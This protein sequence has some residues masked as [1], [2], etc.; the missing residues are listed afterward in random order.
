[1]AYSLFVTSHILV[2][3]G[4]TGSQASWHRPGIPASLE[5]CKFKA[6]P[7]YRES[8]GPAWATDEALPHNSEKAKEGGTCTRSYSQFAFQWEERVVVVP[9]E[10]THLSVTA[11]SDTLV[12]IAPSVPWACL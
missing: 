7:G 9:Q 1:M 2:I 3:K 6:N 10:A 4:F 5:D 12:T 11:F 8:S